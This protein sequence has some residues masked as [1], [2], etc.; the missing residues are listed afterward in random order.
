METSRDPTSI[1]LSFLA[2]NFNYR[3]SSLR[4]DFPCVNETKKRKATP[5]LTAKRGHGQL[6]ISRKTRNFVAAACLFAHEN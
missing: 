5:E 1:Q 6:D 3:Y 4:I 2:I